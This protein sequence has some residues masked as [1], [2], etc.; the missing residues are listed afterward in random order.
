VGDAGNSASTY[1]PRI[2]SDEIFSNSIPRKIEGVVYLSPD[3]R[4]S[5]IM[6]ALHALTHSYIMDFW[7]MDAGVLL[8]NSNRPAFRSELV[9]IAR[10]HGL[11]DVLNYHL[12][13]LREIFGYPGDIPLPADYRPPRP[14]RRLIRAAVRRTDYLFFGDILLGFTI[15]SY[16]NRFYYFKE[17]AFPH[18]DIIAL[19]SGIDSHSTPGI[20]CARLLHLVKSA[21]RVFFA[22]RR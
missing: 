20:Y 9:D 21:F 14:I 6:T 7:F 22:G 19:E 18:R 8:I 2:E 5:L 16:R 11:G 12:W 17:M 1:L 3:P 15:D 10:Q 4:H 13:A